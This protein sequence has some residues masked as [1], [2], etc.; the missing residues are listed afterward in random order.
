M[1]NDPEDADEAP[2]CA[3]ARRS[4]LKGAGAAG[5]GVFFLPVLPRKL[6]AA[7]GG[8]GPARR[9]L[10]FNLTGGIRSSAAFYAALDGDTARNPWGVIPGTGTPFAL[11][12]LLDDGLPTDHKL[13][14]PA[15]DRA[16]PPDA[17]KLGPSWDYAAVPRLREMARSFSVLGTWHRERGDHIRARVE[18][19]TGSSTGSEP[20]LLTRIRRAME[21]TATDAPPFHLMPSA[22]FGLAPGDLARY[23]PVAMSGPRSLPNSNQVDPDLR[24]AAGNDFGDDAM[25]ARIDDRRVSR[26]A[27]FGK[28]LAELFALH[29]RSARTFGKQLAE[30]WLAVGPATGY[31]PA[32]TAAHGE[33]RL[34]SGVTRPLGNDMLYELCVRA[35]GPDPADPAA[36]R[37]MPQPTLHAQHDAVV[38]TA[39]A[40]RLLQFGSPAVVVEIGTFDLHSGEVDTGP[41]LYRFLGRLWATVGWLLGRMVEPGGS[42]SMLDRTLCATMSDFGRDPGL[43]ATGFNGGDGTDHGSDPTCYY[44]A[45][46]VMGAGVT[47][48]RMVGGVSPASFD[49]SRDPGRVGPRRLLAG[50][51]AALGIDHRDPRWGFEDVTDTDPLGDLWKV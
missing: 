31:G 10:I 41:V 7:G 18:E 47:G 32:S 9:L 50:L 1:L 48:G 25:R 36:T 21:G 40:I 15:R 24:A 22:T 19:V 46:A 30:P 4:F 20:G 42:G 44:L 43:G 35:L 3:L 11:G 38:N 5:A 27:G 13:Y 33:V 17:Y 16:L 6:W 28:S 12:R 37:P 45:H 26:R 29:R 2:A 8:M 49:A 51:L 39:L 23:A 14:R 34:P